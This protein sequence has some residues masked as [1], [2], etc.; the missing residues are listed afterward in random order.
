[1]SWWFSFG[2]DLCSALAVYYT[3]IY[4]VCSCSRLT[5]SLRHKCNKPRTRSKRCDWM[6]F[7]GNKTLRLSRCL[8]V[9]VNLTPR[10]PALIICIKTIISYPPA[11]SPVWSHPPPTHLGDSVQSLSHSPRPIIPFSETQIRPHA[12]KQKH[13]A[14][15]GTSDHYAV[16]NI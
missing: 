5:K 15:P 11:D 12:Q 6:C 14:I 3:L 13:A 8:M 7:G 16:N 1:M 4:Y 10:R 9:R 2:L